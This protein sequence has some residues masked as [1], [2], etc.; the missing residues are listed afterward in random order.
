MTLPIKKFQF[1]FK[2]QHLKPV[3]GPFL[4]LSKS[5]CNDPLLVLAVASGFPN[6][7]Q[8]QLHQSPL[9]HKAKNTKSFLHPSQLP[10]FLQLVFQPLMPVQTGFQL[11]LASQVGSTSDHFSNFCL[12]NTPKI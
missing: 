12:S 2:S 7:N 4:K 9:S 8:S 11:E 1:L 6:P 10:I 3:E 5:R